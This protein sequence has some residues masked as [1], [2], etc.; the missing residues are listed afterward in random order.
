M[1]LNRLLRPQSVAVIGGGVWCENVIRRC[2]AFGF[3]G[4][5]WPV[6]PIKPEVGGEPA[7]RSL[8]DLPGSPDAT[9]IGINR[10]ASVAAVAELAA[11]EA[12][13]AVCFASGFQEATAELAD[14]GALQAELVQKAGAMPVL[15]PNCYGFINALDRVS[16]WPDQH[17]LA[18]T[19]RG[20]AI[21]GQ[22]S[23]VLLN[24]T[25]Q[26][27]G[28]PIA[29]AI[30]VGNQAQTSFADLGQSLLQDERVTALG[31][32]LEGIGDLAAFEAL[33]SKAR[34][35]GKPIAVLKT[36]ASEQAQRA[37]ISHTASLVGSEAGAAALFTRLGVGQVHGLGAFLELLKVLHVA[38]PLASPR[39]ASASCSGGEASLMADS[40]LG[41]YLEFPALTAAQTNDL[42]AALGPKVSLANP[43]DYHTYI[44]DDLEAMIACYS[45]LLDPSLGMGCLVLD[46]PRGDRC[47][48]S[49]WMTAIDAAEAATRATGVPLA[50]LSTL[51]ETMP[52]AVAADIM[53]RGMVPLQGL[54]DA[55]AALDVAAQM[56]AQ[57]P[58]MDPLLIPGSPKAPTL[59]D[60]GASKKA[61]SSH[62]LPI[63]KSNLADTPEEAVA[64]AAQ[65]GYPVVVKGLGV[66]HKTEAG[67]LRLNLKDADAVAAACD[68]MD[69]ARFLIEEMVTDCPGELLVSVLRDPAHGFVLTIGAGG[70]L[71][72]IMDDTQSL[73]VPA[74]RAMVETAL[75]RLRVWPVLAGYR[76]ADAVDLD[77]ILGTIARLQDFVADRQGRLEEVEINPLL[78]GPKRAVVADALL[79]LE[80]EP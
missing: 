8:T 61:L 47:D 11:R 78:C 22:S 44:W 18:P 1:T 45:A 2:R 4:A 26:M 58:T 40:A 57:G 30:T 32:Y 37:A 60:E 62:G 77:A 23:N 69:A 19:E 12:G 9:F 24:L 16:L 68:E 20:V 6:H 55:L 65:I 63:P 21:I 56:G 75:K 46:L 43:L 38:G 51:P 29:Y 48:P 42:R 52:E 73:L 74:P 27:R 54:N 36:G 50:I 72:E 79:R 66:A 17:G 33:A 5:I 10:T 41:T 3:R 53:A 13:G 28:L 25:M 35:M 15:G 59:I 49:A 70:T 39:I 31:L 76:G 7:Y 34:S 64:A 71:T 14:G 67:A 80:G